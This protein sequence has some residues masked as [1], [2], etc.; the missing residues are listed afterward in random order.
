MQQNKTISLLTAIAISFNAMIGA[1]VLLAPIMLAKSAGPASVFTMLIAFL[2]VTA[3]GASLA[4]AASLFPGGGWS[5]RYASA[6]AGHKVGLLASYTYIFGLL[7][8]V[9]VLT[10]QAGDWLLFERIPVEFSRTIGIAV[11]VLLAISVL[12]GGKSSATT[13][14]VIAGLVLFSLSVAGIFGFLHFR[15]ETLKPFNPH[16]LIGILSATPIVIFSL[17]GFESVT[18][19]YSSMENPSKNLVIAIVSSISLVTIVYSIFIFGTIFAIPK[20]IIAEGSVEIPISK[21]LKIAFPQATILPPIIRLGALAG[22]IGTIHS[23]LWAVPK[24]LTDIT[25]QVR[26]EFVQK[27][28]VETNFLNDRNVTIFCTVF[29]ALTSLFSGTELIVKTV[30][31]FV[32]ITYILA[33]SGLLFIPEEWKN[34]RNLITLVGIIGGIAT[35][36]FSIKTILSKFIQI[37]V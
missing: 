15:P 28:L 26:S 17:L 27:K 19:L 37:V 16:G 29:V 10:Q 24:L 14:Y 34:G 1:G 5:Y 30:P 25:K 18:S 3:I 13:Q 23:L 22:I 33:I 35:A 21:F 4:R 8:A 12:I 11:L 32:M 6:W 7:V 36:I 20:Q 31:F 2:V 9:A